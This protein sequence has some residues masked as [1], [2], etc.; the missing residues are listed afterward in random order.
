MS[1][2]RIGPL[3][4]PL[5]YQIND[6]GTLSWN[7]KIEEPA[8]GPRA[9]SLSMDQQHALGEAKEFLKVTLKQ[10]RPAAVDVL[11]QARQ[12][13]ISVRTLRRAKAWLQVASE[14]A[15]DGAW[16]WFMPT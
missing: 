12:L 5:G 4:P 11:Q 15:E 13:G 8:P 10:G 1:R 7:D 2:S 6:D 9:P 16:R 14:R 3:G